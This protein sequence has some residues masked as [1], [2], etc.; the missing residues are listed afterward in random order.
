[1]I[2]TVTPNPALDLT[3]HVDQL[4]IGD[5]HRADAGAV[6][7]GG[8]GL[9]VARVA[10]AEGAVVRAITT[11]G[12]RS[13]EEFAEELGRSGVPHSLVRVAQDTRRSIAI[14][15]EALGD[16]TIVNERGL[17]PSDQE[18]A[19]LLAAVVDALPSA[20]VLV[21][22][23]SLPPGAP[24]GFLPLLIA[25]AKDAGVPVIVDTSG[26]ALL[27]AAAAGAS[28]LKPNRAELAE[29][30][31]ITDPVDGARALLARGAELVL[32]SLGAAGMLAVT[33][34]EL[35]HARLDE[36]LAGNPTGAGDAAVAACAVLYAEG[37]RDPELILRRAAAWSAAAVLMPLAGDISPQWPTL[38]AQLR[39]SRP[40]PDSVRKDL[41]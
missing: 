26:P 38:A 34:S 31:G 17:N 10:H 19:D 20:R 29:A 37:E 14:V 41:S 3:W 16:T 8:K 40:D 15:D 39:V 35:V 36:P 25:V 30:T 27:R 23:G 11:A 22:S 33:A 32:L 7:A 28:V 5:T 21:I 18:W 9:N 13:G 2:L 12:G 24:D 4:R 6:R 1:M